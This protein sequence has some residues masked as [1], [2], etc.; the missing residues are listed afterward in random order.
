MSKKIKLKIWRGDSKSGG[1]K[2][3]RLRPMREK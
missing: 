2:D 3:E 1:L